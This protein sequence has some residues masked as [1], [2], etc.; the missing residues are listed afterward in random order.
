MTK[1]HVE[2]GIDIRLLAAGWPD[3]TGYSATDPRATATAER[4]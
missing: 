1:S 3:W 4:S 2:D